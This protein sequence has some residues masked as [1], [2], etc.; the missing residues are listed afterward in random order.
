MS[1]NSQLR[2]AEANAQRDMLLAAI[3]EA[4]RRLHEETPPL[5]DLINHAMKDSTLDQSVKTRARYAW[6]WAVHGSA[7]QLQMA[8]NMTDPDFKDDK[9]MR[10]LLSVKTEELEK[11]FAEQ[12]DLRK[13]VLDQLRAK[14]LKVNSDYGSIWWSI[15]NL[16]APETDFDRWWVE[17]VAPIEV[18]ARYHPYDE[19][20]LSRLQRVKTEAEAL[21]KTLPKH[22]RATTVITRLLE[23]LEFQE[24]WAKDLAEKNAQLSQEREAVINGLW[25]TRGRWM[26]ALVSLATERGLRADDV[27]MVMDEKDREINRKFVDLMHPITNPHL[28]DKPKAES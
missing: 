9:P 11:L 12:S 20:D 2:R 24:S 1:H 10:T 21:L 16:I 22:L 3:G 8:L 18:E 25:E 15:H 14:T 26:A 27:Y 5:V 7:L 23:Q 28:K 6:E 17:W 19:T 4:A 13:F